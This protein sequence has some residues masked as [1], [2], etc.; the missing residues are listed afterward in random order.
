M[1]DGERARSLSLIPAGTRCRHWIGKSSPARRATAWD[2]A[3]SA[4]TTKRSERRKGVETTQ[5]G[6]GVTCGM[7]RDGCQWDGSVQ[8]G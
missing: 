5:A 3:S 7:N 8:D 2:E 4:S 1:S 6:Y